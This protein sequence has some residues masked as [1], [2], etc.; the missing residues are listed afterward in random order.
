MRAHTHTHTHTD[1]CFYFFALTSAV[2]TNIL[3]HKSW[4]ASLLFP[5]GEFLYGEE[6]LYGEAPL[7]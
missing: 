4:G 1:S 2:V 3:E 7:I 5:Y 6:V